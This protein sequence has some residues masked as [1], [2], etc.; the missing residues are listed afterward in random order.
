MFQVLAEKPHEKFTTFPTEEELSGF[1]ANKTF[2]TTV[3]GKQYIDLS[4]I[5]HERDLHF[6]LFEDFPLKSANL[7]HSLSVYLDFLD[8]DM[9]I[10]FYKHFNSNFFDNFSDRTLAIILT[11]QSNKI[12]DFTH[13]FLVLRQTTLDLIEAYETVYGSID[14]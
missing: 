7:Q 12:S 6:Y 13:G 3:K 10:S 2:V 1:L 4:G 5:V 9:Q 8:K 11:G 14:K